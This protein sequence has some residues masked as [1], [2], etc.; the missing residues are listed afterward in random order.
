[1]QL[2]VAVLSQSG[3]R[4]VNEDACGFWPG[5]G[6]CFCVLSDGA[7]GHGGGDVASKIV[8]QQVLEFF[9][10][11]PE[12]SADAIIGAMH[13][14]NDALLDRQRTR[15]EVA[16]MRATVVALAID[17]YHAC[18]CWG[19]I[20]DSRLYCFR[21]GRIV[22][23]TRDDSVVQDLVEAGYLQPHETRQS[24]E[25]SK[26][27]KALGHEHAFDPAVSLEP[28]QLSPGDKFL[29]C[30]DGLW[31]YL[32]DAELESTSAATSSPREWLRS[33]EERVL[34]RGSVEQDNY[35]ALAV[36]CWADG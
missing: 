5:N 11:R 22:A 15:P 6:A 17:S 26:L 28:L 29:L 23:K 10:G 8:V 14:A 36:W 34:E 35:S 20:G 2:E 16:D 4:A 1:M 30:T 33:I 21:D 12:C 31:E 13:H 18:A 24:P 19:H 7:G 25:R 9:R 32:D 3:G 27:L